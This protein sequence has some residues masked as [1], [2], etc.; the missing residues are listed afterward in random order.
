MHTKSVLR[1]LYT[2]GIVGTSTT[3]FQLNT[4]ANSATGSPVH[5]KFETAFTCLLKQCLHATF[6]AMSP[7]HFH[8]PPHS[9][10]APPMCCP[11]SSTSRHLSSSK[12]LLSLGPFHVSSIPPLSKLI[13]E[14]ISTIF[15]H[16]SLLLL[17]ASFCPTMAES[18]QPKPEPNQHPNARKKEGEPKRR[19]EEGLVQVREKNSGVRVRK[20][21]LFLSLS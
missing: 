7:C 17:H 18:I 6:H 16:F 21:L 5:S 15:H 12:R 2:V 20:S 10:H 11:H 8:M 13:K 3:T 9:I 4:F 14:D 1:V 19:K